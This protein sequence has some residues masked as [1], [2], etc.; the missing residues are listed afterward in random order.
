MYLHGCAFF[1]QEGVSCPLFSSPFASA[2]FTCG[3]VVPLPAGRSIK[4]G[5]LYI[6][7]YTYIQMVHTTKGTRVHMHMELI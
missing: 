2:L 6:Y 5:V 1:L 4:M 7:L 3:G